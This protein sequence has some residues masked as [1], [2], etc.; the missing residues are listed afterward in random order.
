MVIKHTYQLLTNVSY[1]C[2]SPGKFWGN[3]ETYHDFPYFDTR[4]IPHT[5]RIT[6]VSTPSSFVSDTMSEKHIS[7]TVYWSETPHVR[8]VSSTFT[9]NRMWCHLHSSSHHLTG[10]TGVTSSFHRLHSSFNLTHFTPWRT[11]LT[12]IFIITID[13][14]ITTIY[15]HIVCMT[16]T[17]ILFDPFYI[18]FPF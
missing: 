1:G 5:T 11:P 12:N 13:H 14:R 7:W 17:R 16:T 2:T 4:T 3:T 6:C 9:F 15:Q 18:V 8:L 10:T